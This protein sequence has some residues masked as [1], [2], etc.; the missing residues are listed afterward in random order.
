MDNEIVAM[1]YH[2]LTTVDA[3][4]IDFDA[5]AANT[6]DESAGKVSVKPTQV[7]EPTKPLKLT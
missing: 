1:F 5:V 6:G 3:K 2:I 4:N 7:D